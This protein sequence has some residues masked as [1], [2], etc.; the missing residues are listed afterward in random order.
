MSGGIDSSVTALLLK[1]Q[2]FDVIGITIC[3]DG[4]CDDD[5]YAEFAHRFP[6]KG[7]RIGGKIRGG[8]MVVV[9]EYGEISLPPCQYQ[10]RRRE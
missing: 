1:R 4:T 7:E 2:G 9:N 6:F 8:I 10:K 3:G 5:G